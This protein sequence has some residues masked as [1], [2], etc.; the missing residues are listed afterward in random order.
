M[1]K[2]FGVY[3]GYCAHDAGAAYI[4]DGEIK[5]AI[6]EERPR[7]LKVYLDVEASPILSTYRIEKEFNLKLN[8]ADWICTASPMGIDIPFL[9]EHKIPKQK[10]FITNHHEAH[11]Y[12]AYYTSGFN[13]KTLVVSFDAGGLSKSKG[14]N[15]TYGKTYLAENNKMVLINTFPMGY[16]AS[17]PCMYAMVT[18]NLGWLINKDEGKVTGLAGYGK[19]REEIYSA[20]EKICWY[21]KG[22]KAFVPQGQAE[23]ATGINMVLHNFQTTG[24]LKPIDKHEESR[25]DLAHN[26]QLFLENKV[27]EYLNHLHELYPTYKK[28][29]VAGGVF[30]NVKLNQRINELD[31]IDE[32]YVYPAMNDAGLALGTILKKA[33][34]LGEWKTKRFDHL[35]YGTKYSQNHIDKLVEGVNSEMNSKEKVNRTKIDIKLIAKYLNEG[36]IIGWFKGKFEFG[37]RALG[38]RSILVRP[39]DAETHENLNKRLGRNEVMPFAPIVIGEKANDIFVTNNKS[40]Y[41]AEFMTMCYE[42]RKEWID[43]IPAVVHKVDKSARPQLV[44]EKNPFYDVLVEYEKLSGIPVLLNTSFNVHGE[45]IIDSPDQAITHLLNGVVDY[46]VMEDFIYR[47][48]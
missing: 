10:I 16:T 2:L 8:E 15:S 30:A 3:G 6:Q 21:D 35:F 19:Y 23:T 14:Y 20:F 1:S 31:W 40:H 33:V 12:G 22:M 32:V 45:P 17:I 39:T 11:C 38:A 28:I 4:E 26:M 37:P 5:S 42:T 41:T 18:R 48:N 24:I 29:A 46:L 27:I 47:V 7:R 43:R 25:A 34:E 13:E 44:Y 9:V 36:S